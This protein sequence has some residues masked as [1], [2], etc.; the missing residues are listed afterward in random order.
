VTAGPEAGLVAAALLQRPAAPPPRFRGAGEGLFRVSG[1]GP[2]LL[3]FA[4]VGGHALR[5][6]RRKVEPHP[7]LQ[8]RG[9]RGEE[10]RGRVLATRVAFRLLREADAS[11]ART[12]G[13]KMRSKMRAAA[14]ARGANVRATAPRRVASVRAPSELKLTS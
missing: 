13:G 12:R 11:A 10:R 3:L 14:T 6:L 5:E 7:P 9:Q 4:A 1:A 8:V 2:G